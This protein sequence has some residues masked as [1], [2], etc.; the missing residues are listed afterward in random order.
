MLFFSFFSFSFLFPPEP[1]PHTIQLGF[2]MW[3]Y[4]IR[5]KYGL[6]VCSLCFSVSNTER[7]TRACANQFHHFRRQCKRPTNFFF[8]FLKNKMQ[9]KAQC[10]AFASRSWLCDYS[11]CEISS[12]IVESF[13]T[14]LC[15]LLMKMD[16]QWKCKICILDSSVRS[17][18]HVIMNDRSIWRCVFSI[19]VTRKVRKEKKKKIQKRKKKSTYINLYFTFFFLFFSFFFPTQKK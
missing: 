19:S 14:Q 9:G 17:I 1:R 15:S 10:E 16:F 18:S 4:A 7:Q 13:R 2:W 8:F 11:R 12:G 3:T 6:C 5:Q